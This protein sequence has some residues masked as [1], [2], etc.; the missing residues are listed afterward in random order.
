MVTLGPLT[1]AHADA[2]LRWMLDPTVSKNLGLRSEPTAEKT[3]QWLDRAAGDDTIEARA[4][5]SDG[6]HVGNVV[7]DQ[8]DRH[9]SRAR[10][11]IYVGETSA[12]SRG[13]GKSA[14]Q[15]AL[16][17]AFGDLG[18]HKVWL[19]VHGRNAA[20][21]AAYKAVGFLVE[22]THRDEFVLDGERLAEIYMGALA[23]E[24]RTLP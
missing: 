18:L 24:R 12:R 15:L 13:V 4:I 2:M 22:G 5:L 20:A 8:I 7:L 11:S 10:L 14:V 16:E 6:Q 19:T 9:V 17:L 3:A 1:P 23:S 21:I